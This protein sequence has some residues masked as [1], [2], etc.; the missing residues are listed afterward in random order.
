MESR[1]KQVVV[2]VTAGWKDGENV[3]IQKVSPDRAAL[4]ADQ[5]AAIRTALGRMER[6]LRTSA[7]QAHLVLDA[8]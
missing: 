3:I 4:M 5:I 1:I 6:D 7:A 8:A 2:I